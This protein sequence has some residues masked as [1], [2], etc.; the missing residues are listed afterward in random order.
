MPLVPPVSIF[1]NPSKDQALAALPPMA[2]LDFLVLF[3]FLGFR[4]DVES[5]CRVSGNIICFPKDPWVFLGIQSASRKITGIL[6]SNYV[7]RPQ[8]KK[9]DFYR[10]LFYPFNHEDWIEARFS[11]IQTSRFQGLKITGDTQRTEFSK[12]HEDIPSQYQFYNWFVLALSKLL[13]WWFHFKQYCCWFESIS[14][15]CK[16]KEKLL[17]ILTYVHTFFFSFHFKSFCC[18]F[19]WFRG[20]KN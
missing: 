1:L 20:Q 17:Y 10:W 19:H 5:L 14:S 8:S 13:W 6:P 9:I 4:G 11:D 15:I 7:N 16:K 12:N 18:H 3:L 2:A